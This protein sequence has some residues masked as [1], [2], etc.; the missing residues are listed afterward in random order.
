MSNEERGYNMSLLMGKQLI[1]DQEF[2]YDS[3]NRRHPA[4]EELLDI[5]QYRDLVLQLIRRDIIARYKRSTLGI[6]W[7]M[8]QPLGMMVVMTIVFSALFHR[9]EGYVVYL[10]SG[11]VAWTFFAQ[12]TTAAITHIVWGGALIKRIYI[13][14]TSFSISSIGT[15]LINLLLS[16]I[17]L[18]IIMLVVGQSITWAFLF[19]PVPILLL[20]TFA[21]GV[22]LILSTLAVYFPDIKEMYQVVVQAWMYLTP[23]IYPENI[24][25]DAYRFLLLHLNPMYYL[26]KMFRSTIYEGKIPSVD[27]ILLGALISFGTL[28]VGWVY[29]SKKADEF[30]YLA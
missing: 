17:P 21:L 24:L 15:G 16:L 27:I 30:A 20:G 28:A 8:L 9:V 26:I 19:I 2:T 23:I 10:L 18:L 14:M 29:F 6:M 13:P 1:L 7:T 5:F 3:A 22:S 25:P 12:T 11:L 4:I